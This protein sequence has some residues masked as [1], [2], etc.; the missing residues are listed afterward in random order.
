M[1]IIKTVYTYNYFYNDKKEKIEQVKTPDTSQNCIQLKI[2]YKP[3]A[4]VLN[5]APITMQYRDGYA[6]ES[7]IMF[8]NLRFFL[9]EVNRFNQKAI[10]RNIAT[11]EPIAEEIASAFLNN[12]NEIAKIKILSL[13]NK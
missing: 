8:S 9:D 5:V 1:N 6:M 2:T 13:L 3:G 12:E 4:V 11:I 7:F 10:D